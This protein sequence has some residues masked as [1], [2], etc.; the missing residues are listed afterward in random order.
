LMNE[1]DNRMRPE[2][3]GIGKLFGKIQDA[4]I[5]ADAQ[6][7]QIIIWNSAATKMFGYSASEALE[8]RIEELVPEPLKA[9]HRAGMARYA[10][11]GHGPFIDS[12]RLLELPALKKDGEEIRIELSLSPIGPVD[13]R[14]DSGGRF[15]L[16]IVRDITDRKQAEEEV[17]RLNGILEELKNLVGK[18]VETQ[19]EQQRR[20]AYE[21]HEG[22][23]Q[24]AAAAHLQL[25]AFYSRYPI[26]T[27]RSQ[28]DL[29]RAMELVRWTIADARRIT[30]NLRPTVLD[31]FGLAAAIPLEIQRLH[32]DG[33]LID[34]EEGI[35]DERLPPRVE[36][37]LFR[38]VQEALANVRKHAKTRQVRIELGF[39]G[40]KVRLEV[41]DHGCGFDSGR[42]GAG[43]SPGE[44]VGLAEMRERITLLG[45]ELKIDSKPGRGTSLVTE[46][47]LPAHEA[48]L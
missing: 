43:S 1:Q 40:N 39:L 34:Y 8:V 33:Y 5:V 15:V 7:Q 11:T 42:Q 38:V 23:A 4:V 17:R 32:E 45:G 26:E 9:R 36:N 44:G 46:V 14:G 25:Q 6:T 35:N 30:T 47:P 22:L 29:E 13:G 20:V 18:L 10:G 37:A 12:D 24:V 16:A 31:D 48:S 28:S 19:E 2:D 41:R 21:L 3:L 27:E